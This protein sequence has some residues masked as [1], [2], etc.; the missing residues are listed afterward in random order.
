MTTTPTTK[1]AATAEI[2][3][4]ILREG[5]GSGAWHGPDLKAALADVGSDVAFWRPQPERHNI[6]EIALHHAYCARNVRARLAG[7]KPGASPRAGG[8]WCAEAG[9][10][11]TPGEKVRALVG[12]EQQ[13]LGGGGG[14]VAAGRV[15]PPL[16]EAERLEL[17]LGITCHA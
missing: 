6:A 1:I 9:R 14:D 17:V 11:T 13:A 4:R 2:L 7:G 3:E 16:A 10:A 15:T 5:Y 8:D 12:A